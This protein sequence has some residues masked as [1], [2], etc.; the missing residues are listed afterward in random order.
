MIKALF[1]LSLSFLLY[2]SC[3]REYSCEKCIPVTLPEVQTVSVTDVNET[4]AKFNGDLLKIGDTSVIDFGF[5]WA[6]TPNPTDNSNK[7]SDGATSSTQSFSNAVTGLSANQTYYVKAYAINSKGTVYGQEISFITPP[8]T[9]NN[10]L[11]AYYPFNGNTN[12]ES[13]NNNHATAS[14]GSFTT[15]KTGSSNRAY[16][17]DG[18]NYLRINNS[19]TLSSI[20]N[21]ITI[22]AWVYNEHPEAYIVCKAAPAGPTMQFRLYADGGGIHFANYGKA[23]DFSNTLSPTNTWKYIAVTCDG[24]AAKLYLNGNLV[25][26]QSLHDD[27]SVNNNTTDMYIGDDTHGAIELYTGKL[28]EIRIYCRVLSTAEVL[29]L[30]NL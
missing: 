22:S 6:S 23:A 9:L 14:G 1:I 3:T 30:Y 27:S 2:I 13:G 7:I 18:S 4:S 24:N 21:T 29:R 10:C 16:Y 20:P 25:S 8:D 19:A 28:D 26:T 17:F 11:Q 15:D 5:C 12:D